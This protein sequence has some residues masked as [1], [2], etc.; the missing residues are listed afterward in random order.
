MKVLGLCLVAGLSMSGCVSITNNGL[1]MGGIED[2]I[3]GNTGPIVT[4]YPVCRVR[5]AH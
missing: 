3:G 5:P 1:P 4:Q 2:I